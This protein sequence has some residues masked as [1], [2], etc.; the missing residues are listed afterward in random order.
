MAVTPEPRVLLM[1]SERL[2][3]AIFAPMDVGLGAQDASALLAIG[4]VVRHEG[5]DV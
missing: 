1:L 5:A 2:L 3:A 4:D